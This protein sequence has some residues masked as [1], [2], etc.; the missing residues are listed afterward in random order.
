MVEDGSHGINEG[1]VFYL[2]LAL[3]RRLGSPARASAQ[4][5]E[6]PA[7]A[8][9]AIIDQTNAYRAAKGFRP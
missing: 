9:A 1:R 7:S 3:R 4:Q 8:K 2:W 5:F 6:V